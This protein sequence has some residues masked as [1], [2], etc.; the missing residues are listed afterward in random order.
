[1]TVEKGERELLGSVG[2]DG[3]IKI[4]ELSDEICSEVRSFKYSATHEVEKRFARMRGDPGVAPIPTCIVDGGNGAGKGMIF[5]GFSN[6]VLGAYEVSTGLCLFKFD[7]DTLSR[8]HLVSVRP[9][10][11]QGL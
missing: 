2:A 7:S 11:S 10:P 4:W 8:K 1:M 6:S 9:T 5:V 3:N